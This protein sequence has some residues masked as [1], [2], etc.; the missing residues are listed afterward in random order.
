MV[1]NDGKILICSN[2]KSI[3][4]KTRLNFESGHTATYISNK[5]M[6]LVGQQNTRERIQR[7]KEEGTT[8]DE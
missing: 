5:I 1:E 7:G 2:E 3:M 6:S 4:N 8:S